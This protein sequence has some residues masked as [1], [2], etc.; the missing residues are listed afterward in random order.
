MNEPMMAA[1]A[2]A[3]MSIVTILL[4]E[5]PF[6]IFHDPEKTPK[7]ILYL[8]DVLPE[9][10]IAMLIIYCLRTVSIVTSPFGIPEALACAI[11]AVLQYWKENIILSIVGGTAVYMVLIQL[12]FV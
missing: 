11:V 3:I 1:I 5:T 8:G 4:R 2:I 12:V 7:I 9:A 6:L 10:I